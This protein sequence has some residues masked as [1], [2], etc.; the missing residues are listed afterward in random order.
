[1]ATSPGSLP[2]SEHTSARGRSV[3]DPD[4]HR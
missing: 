3:A 1:M 2:R 4:A